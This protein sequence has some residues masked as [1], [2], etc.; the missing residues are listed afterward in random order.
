MRCGWVCVG[1]FCGSVGPVIGREMHLRSQD[2]SVVLSP[3]AVLP[4]W[5]GKDLCVALQMT[6]LPS[7]SQVL[8]LSPV[9]VSGR[10]TSR[11][12][13]C[14]VYTLT[15]R[16]CTVRPDPRE[17][18]GMAMSSGMGVTAPGSGFP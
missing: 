4:L 17:E 14:L 2:A 8:L 10:F 1:T 5:L 9:W 15:D 6:R 16:S 7:D 12:W 18:G 11:T 3:L 13:W